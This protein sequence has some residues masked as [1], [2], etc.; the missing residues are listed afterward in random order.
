MKSW[1]EFAGRIFRIRKCHG[2][3]GSLRLACVAVSRHANLV[4]A[5]PAIGMRSFK[6]A[7]IEAPITPVPRNA[8]DRAAARYYRSVNSDLAT[9]A[10]FW[11]LETQIDRGIQL[12]RSGQER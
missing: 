11:R 10:V 3:T 12:S 6:K 1:E 7:V 8:R 5:I 4:R 2:G 9:G